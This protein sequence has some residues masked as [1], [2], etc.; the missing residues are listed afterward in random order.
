[1][2]N[3]I[4][5]KEI[6]KE[7]NTITYDYGVLGEVGRYFNFEKKLVVE[8][9]RN[10]ESVENAQAVLPLLCNML[11]LAWLTDSEIYLN[12]VDKNFYEAIPEIKAGFQKMYPMLKF[13]GKVI[14]KNIVES[15]LVLEKRSGAFF[16]GGVDATTTFLQHLEE[17]PYLFTM[18]GLDVDLEDKK[19][20]TRVREYV[21]DVAKEYDTEAI[22]IK[23]NFRKMVKEG[24]LEKLVH[25]SGDGWWHGFQCGIGLIGH[26]AP[27]VQILKVENVYI[28]STYSKYAKGKYTCGSDPI[29]DNQIHFAGCQTIHDGYEFTR[30]EKVKYLCEYYE[31]N[32][33]EI[34]IRVCWESDGGS[35]CS[36]CE[37]CCTTI[38]EIVAEGCNPNAFG[39]MWN[40]RMIRKFRNNILSKYTITE[41]DINDYW[42]P[43]LR[44]MKE[45]EKNIRDIG[46]YKWLLK[47]DIQKIND[48]RIKKLRKCLFFRIVGK[49]IRKVKRIFK[50]SM[51]KIANE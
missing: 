32:K 30:Q 2:K 9:S 14:V 49:V 42:V 41:M 40:D 24:E 34:P 3:Q 18:W 17:K 43:T 19:G 26:I 38:M 35:N 10:I 48:T 21:S 33:R 16:S 28:A 23:S 36:V 8:Y 25:K 51:R 13:K 11:V 31:K 39:F 4:Y 50:Y 12:E 1:M 15:K 20:W 6:K 37:K 45:N 29:I 27:L 7:Q 5:I 22:Y 46:K 44:R 47:C